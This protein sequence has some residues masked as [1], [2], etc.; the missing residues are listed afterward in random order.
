MSAINQSNEKLGPTH[1]R[2]RNFCDEDGVKVVID[3][4]DVVK[5]TPQGFWIKKRSASS[6]MSEKDL[7][8]RGEI[9]LVSKN[10]ER[11]WAYP[12]LEESLKSLKRRKMRQLDL[13]R[14]QL[15]QAEL[16]VEVFDTVLKTKRI[17]DFLNGD[18]YN[19]G[20]VVGQIPSAE[21]VV[22]DY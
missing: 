6:W 9:K 22:W 13:L 8:K 1:Y 11:R 5:A 21:N 10:S 3:E 15:E 7:K 17:D 2:A 4:W 19:R 16:I 18:F 14:W 12:T 20:V